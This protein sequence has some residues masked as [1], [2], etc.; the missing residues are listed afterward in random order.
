MGI[1]TEAKRLVRSGRVM[2]SDSQFDTLGVYAARFDKTAA[3]NISDLLRCAAER[4]KKVI[5]E[6]TLDRLM[7]IAEFHHADVVLAWVKDIRQFMALNSKHCCR[8][9]LERHQDKSFLATVRVFRVESETEACR[10]YATL[11]PAGQGRSF[12]DTVRAVKQ[13]AKEGVFA[14]CDDQVLRNIVSGVSFVEYG[15]DRANYSLVHRAELAMMEYTAFIRKFYPLM[16]HT[17]KRDA[18]KRTGMI[19]ADFKIMEASPRRGQDFVAL[20][21][22]M[23]NAPKGHVV[24]ALRKEYFEESLD[25]KRTDTSTSRITLDVYA[26]LEAWTAFLEDRHPDF[27]RPKYRAIGRDALMKV[28]WTLGGLR[29]AARGM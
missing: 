20:T 17:N 27:R 6:N 9:L 5:R 16:L 2:K 11:D 24:R 29:K 23:D 8:V 1:L 15:K 26:M 21:L 10:L 14:K 12:E 4:G 18:C 7:D 25:G 22:C 28:K 3:A 19:G 13:Y